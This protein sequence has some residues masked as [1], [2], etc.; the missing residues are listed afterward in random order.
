MGRNPNFACQ[1]YALFDPD[2]Y[3]FNLN[4]AVYFHPIN[5]AVNNRN[6][7]FAEIHATNFRDCLSL[8]CFINLIGKVYGYG[9][10]RTV[11]LDAFVLPAGFVI[12]RGVLCST[13]PFSHVK[14]YCNALF[15]EQRITQ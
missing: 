8:F 5:M 4:T 10:R 14:A 7:Y 3:I 12:S 15:H 1:K 13:I 2:T 11:L 9:T 6:A